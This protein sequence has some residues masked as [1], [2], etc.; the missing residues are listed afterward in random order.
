MRA[1]DLGASAP[2]SL[3]R[4]DEN[5]DAG[6][7]DGGAG[8]EVGMETGAEVPE[9]ASS[10]P[11]SAPKAL[12]LA[13]GTSDASVSKAGKVDWPWLNAFAVLGLPKADCTAGSLNGLPEAG[14]ESSY[15][16]A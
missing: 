12:V 16:P 6:F 15:Q 11:L 9:S 5:D 3:R 13:E 4:K 10:C 1:P 7:A 2:E 14:F 8:Q